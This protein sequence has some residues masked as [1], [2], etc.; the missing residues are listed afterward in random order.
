MF[1]KDAKIVTTS[2]GNDLNY[3][4]LIVINASIFY[5]ILP[6]ITDSTKLVIVFDADHLFFT[7]GVVPIDCRYDTTSKFVIKMRNKQKVTDLIRRIISSILSD[8]TVTETHVYTLAQFLYSKPAA[9]NDYLKEVIHRV[10]MGS[11]LT[12]FMTF[13]YRLPYSTHQK[14]IK[15]LI[16]NWMYYSGDSILLKQALLF[17]SSSMLSKN[18][19]KLSSKMM[20]AL[21][22]DILSMPVIQNYILAF[23]H[24]YSH[25]E[26]A[27]KDLVVTYSVMIYE[28]NY[29]TSI[30]NAEQYL[31]DSTVLYSEFFT[32]Y[33]VRRELLKRIKQ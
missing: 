6:S 20:T 8:D 7:Q 19:I 17:L 11:F 9:C 5:R 25:P 15:N 23:K 4:L 29:C 24:L 30:V 14:P 32:E 12:P 13:I 21:E 33:S 22:T 3:K 1:H 16:V 10:K 2:N 28:L 27:Y 26:V 18:P 31:F